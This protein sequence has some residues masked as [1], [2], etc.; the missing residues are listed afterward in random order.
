METIDKIR[1]LENQCLQ[2]S[3]III[4]PSETIREHLITRNV[5]RDKIHVI[6]NGGDIPEEYPALS[7][8]P[9]SYIVYF[10]ALQ[11]WQGV[12]ILLKSLQYL[13][14]KAELKLVVCS[15]HKPKFSRRYQKLA[16][17]L[18]VEDK[19]IWKHQLHKND[20]HQIIQHS[21]CS[22]VPLT[23]CARNLEQGCSPLKIFESMACKTAIVA[24]DLPVVRE[25]LEPDIEAKLFRPDR[26]AELAR[27]IRFLSDYPEFRVKLI[28]NSFHKFESKY[29]WQNI[30]DQ[31]AKFYENLLELSC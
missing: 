12:D 4:C 2:K 1:H 31:L 13:A 15:S 29:T 16:K 27:C 22:V 8:L 9:E 23:E 5:F 20:L 18:G 3:H 14:D 25:I 30:D 7:D 10:G 28:T 17:K 11:P 21:I 6:S 26:P 19:V 24:S